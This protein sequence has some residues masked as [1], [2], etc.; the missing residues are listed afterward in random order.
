VE[1]IMR[2]QGRLGIALVAL[3]FSI[4]LGACQP[5]A[6]TQTPTHPPTLTPTPAPRTVSLTTRDGATLSGTI[7]GQGATAIVFSNRSD[8]GQESW[9]GMATRAAQAG[10]LAL[11]FDYRAWRG[12]GEFDLEQLNQA[13]FDLLA[14]AEFVRSEGAQTIALVGASLGGIASVKD[15]AAI[16]P[17]ALIVIG[18]PMGNPALTIKVEP[19]ELQ[20]DVPKL[21]IAS[22]ADTLVPAAETRHMYDLA[23][24][25]KTYFEY[26]GGAHATDLFLGPSADDLAQKLLDF[27][28]AHAPPQPAPG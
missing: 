28:L 26:P 18:S 1:Q 8:K 3:A 16:A 7:Y 5:A 22:E 9:A 25:P 27:L 24:E 17:A 19:A 15:S 6:P 4:L 20:N 23:A 14:A 13:D 21:F 12:G 11:T 10:Y 2:G